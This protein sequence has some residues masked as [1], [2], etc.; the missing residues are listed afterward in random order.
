MAVASRT[1]NVRQWMVRL[2]AAVPTL[3]WIILA[4]VLVLGASALFGGLEEADG[5]GEVDVP[6]LSVGDE[7]IG[8]EFTATITG[9][10]LYDA[11]PS[12]YNEPEEGNR[13]LVVTARVTNNWTE[14][15]SLQ[16]LLR[17]D[18]LGETEQYTQNRV[19][20]S[21]LTGNPIAIPRVPLDVGYVWEVP[22]DAFDDGD[23]VRITIT[24]R[25]LFTDNFVTFGDYWTD[26]QPAAFVDVTI[27]DRG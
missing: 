18:F 25:T 3:W 8:E 22:A 27:E 7:L 4:A 12:E 23:T 17:L 9:A 14:Y 16:E 5:A 15:T 1:T 19:L 26:P 13:L 20:L 24:A 11:Y 21:D 10:R 2:L 6:V